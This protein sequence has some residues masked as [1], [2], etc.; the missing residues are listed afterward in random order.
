MPDKFV[1]TNDV[2]GYFVYKFTHYSSYTHSVSTYY[3]SR[4]EDQGG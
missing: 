1:K 2:H 4:F 3:F